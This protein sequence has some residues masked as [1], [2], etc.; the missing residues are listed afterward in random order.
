[1]RRLLI[2]LLGLLLAPTACGGGGDNSS[3][4]RVKLADLGIGI[5]GTDR[6]FYGTCAPGRLTVDFR[7]RDE[8]TIRSKGRL[9][10]SLSA[11]EAFIGCSDARVEEPRP[12]RGWLFRRFTGDV[13]QPTKLVCVTEARIDIYVHPVYRSKTN[14]IGGAIVVSTSPGASEPRAL[15]AASFRQSGE[16]RVNYHTPR[17]QVGGDG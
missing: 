8:I 5:G 11:E 2:A 14:L 4:V 1:M 7:P 12:G 9:V 15:L 3:G 6:R 17:C 13:K 10:V 16:S